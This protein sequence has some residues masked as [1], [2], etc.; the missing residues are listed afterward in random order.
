LA[1]VT[2]VILAVLLVASLIASLN[3]DATKWFV[4]GLIVA[5]LTP[6]AW[7]WVRLYRRRGRPD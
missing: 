5:T 3:P 6:L 1:A 2:L 7:L 4:V